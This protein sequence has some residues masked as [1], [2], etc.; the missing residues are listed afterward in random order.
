MNDILD[1]AKALIGRLDNEWLI[2]G[3]ILGL[4]LIWKSP[5]LIRAIFE[6][7]R[8]GKANDLEVEQRQNR[9]Q[10]QIESELAKRE[11]RRGQGRK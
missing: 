8:L 2:C 6:A 5:E 1:P 4:V 9:Y 3:V 7:R 11:K 10:R